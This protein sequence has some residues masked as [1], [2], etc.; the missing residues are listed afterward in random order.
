MFTLIFVQPLFNVLLALY[1]IIPGHSFGLA[2]IGLT[3]LVRLALW[4]LFSKQLHSQKAMQRLQPEVA[5]VRAKA[6]GD[7]QKETAMLMELYKEHGTSPFASLLPVILQLPILIAL[8]SVFNHSL[9]TDQI[10][11]LA[12]P[13]VRHLDFIAGI[14]HHQI[15]FNPSLFG[16]V[17]LTKGNLVLALAAGAAQFLQARLMQPTATPGDDQAKLMQS[18]TYIFPVVTV[19]F[20]LRFPSALAL[21]WTVTSLMAALQ[22][23][24][25]LRKDAHEME[26]VEDEAE[27]G[28]KVIAASSKPKAKGVAK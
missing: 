16:L 3:V 19:V 17:D 7:R 15:S 26:A 13:F 2:V 4:P 1:A 25:V 21:Y 8:V 20:A 23:F 24:L 6:K 18:M 28:P 9:H 12:Y 5:K 27:K 10:A 22:Q 11:K 14:I